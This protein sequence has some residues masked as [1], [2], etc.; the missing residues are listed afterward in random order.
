M[1]YRERKLETPECHQFYKKTSTKSIP[2]LTPIRLSSLILALLHHSLICILGCVTH[3]R[4]IFTYLTTGASGMIQAFRI[5]RA[6]VRIRLVRS[7]YRCAFH[8]LES[9][10]LFS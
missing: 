2:L 4:N 5:V 1:L 8:T 6:T 3:R 10:T 7:R 9:S